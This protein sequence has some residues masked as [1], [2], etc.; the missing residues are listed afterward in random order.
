MRYNVHV[1]KGIVEIEA[2]IRRLFYIVSMHFFLI[3]ITM[4]NTWCKKARNVYN[5]TQLYR[6]GPCCFTVL[7]NIHVIRDCS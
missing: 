5:A 2:I 1:R 6:S 7:K 4:S 3:V